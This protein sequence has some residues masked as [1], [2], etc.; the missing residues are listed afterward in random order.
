MMLGALSTRSARAAKRFTFSQPAKDRPDL[1]AKKRCAATRRMSHAFD[2]G[3]QTVELRL[4]QSAHGDDAFAG[5]ETQECFE[6]GHAGGQLG[7]ARRP[8][9]QHARS[10]IER[11]PRERIPQDKAIA[12]HVAL[13]EHAPDDARRRFGKAARALLR[14]A[15]AP[16]RKAAKDM[17]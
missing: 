6:H 17:P 3:R 7:F 15:R 10:R 14:L 16:W 9:A 13:N 1:L 2:L 12:R 4:R 11:M 5:E 8:I